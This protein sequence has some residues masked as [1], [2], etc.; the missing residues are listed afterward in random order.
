MFNNK[1]VGH[2]ALKALKAEIRGVLTGHTVAMV[3][4]D[5]IKIT[6][7]YSTIIG[8]LFD[9]IIVASTDKDL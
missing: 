1:N 9:T 4:S 2:R 7:M 6:K 3:T 8:H 5:V